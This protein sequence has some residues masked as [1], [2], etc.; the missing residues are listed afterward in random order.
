[1]L[2]PL[3]ARGTKELARLGWPFF[4]LKKN[5]LKNMLFRDVTTV[6]NERKH[7]KMVIGSG[8]DFLS[9]I[10]GRAE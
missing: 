9:L 4:V 1:M 7:F 8:P 10:L 3:A 2:W 5:I 6:F